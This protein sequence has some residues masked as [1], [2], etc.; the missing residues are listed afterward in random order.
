MVD[1]VES[2]PGHDQEHFA[3]A[4]RAVLDLFKVTDRPEAV[5]P[6][7]EALVPKL[8]DHLQVLLDSSP[9]APLA[10]LLACVRALGLG[11]VDAGRLD[12]AAALHA[13]AVRQLD[14]H[15]WPRDARIAPTLMSL[16]DAVQAAGRPDLADTMHAVLIA[17]LEARP[18]APRELL[19][20]E[21]FSAGFQKLNRDKRPDLAQPWLR[22]AF[23]TQTAADPEAWNTTKYR[24]FLGQALLNDGQHAE[25]ESVLRQAFDESVARIARAPAWERH[26]P[27]T[28]A[29]FLARL[30]DT[31]GRPDEAA[32]WRAER[33]K[34]PARLV[35]PASGK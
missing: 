33:D 2:L 19:A 5:R 25:A 27:N 29:G 10:T 7:A 26:F 32:R 12:D 11:L 28:A 30:Y 22:K 16:R 9:Q 14:A 8:Q 35:D 34:H 23:D 31:T 3:E 24:L 6:W 20:R 15:G 17:A 13:E 21:F 18:S 1:K 4:R